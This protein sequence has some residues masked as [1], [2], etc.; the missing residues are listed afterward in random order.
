MDGF[1]PAATIRIY[2]GEADT[3]DGVAVYEK[4]LE[5]AKKAGLMGGAVYRG[6]EG[7]GQGGKMHTARVLRLSE[8]LP[9]MVSV[10]DEPVK[11]DAFVLVV[12]KIMA[13]SGCGGLIT[14]QQVM[15]KQ[16]EAKA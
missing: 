10:T 4:I 14:T 2:V 8:D 9:V 5:D 11:I 15:M 3:V 1:K 7:Y 6:I 12:D 13:A 16:Y